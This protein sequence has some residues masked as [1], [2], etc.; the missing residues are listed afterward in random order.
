MGR[1]FSFAEFV[2]TRARMNSLL[3]KPDE[4][5]MNLAGVSVFFDRFETS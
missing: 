5:S 1:L 2:G 3:P 4:F